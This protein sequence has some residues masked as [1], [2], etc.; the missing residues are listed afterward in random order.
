M[1][2]SASRSG[3]RMWLRLSTAGLGVLMGCLV[4]FVFTFGY[5][6]IA[7]GSWALVSAMFAG[8]VLHLHIVYR[9]HRLE[10]WYS[11]QRL[12]VLR[13]I[14]LGGLGISLIVT[15]YYVYLAVIQHQQ[16]ASVSYRDSFVLA[17]VWSFMTVKWSAGLAY[18]SHKYKVKI[19]GEREYN[20]F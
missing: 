14:S 5:G 13:G 9:V 20:T 6:N 16:S 18:F 2:D 19:E 10:L 8:L 11:A 15:M 12:A 3:W 17:S 1:A 4:F 7:A